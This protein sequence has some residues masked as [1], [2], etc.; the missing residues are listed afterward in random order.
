MAGLKDTDEENEIISSSVAG[1]TKDHL[2]APLG[3]RPRG[4]WRAIFYIIGNESFERLASMGLVMNLSVYLKTK[5]NMY[6]VFLINVVS[7]W[8][9]FCNILPLLGAFIAEKFLGRF[10]TLLLGCSASFIGMTMMALTAG[11]ANLRPASCDTSQSQQDCPQPNAGHLSFLFMALGLIAIGAG[12]IR[13]CCIAF[14]ADQFDATTEEGKKNMLSFYNWWYLSFTATLIIALSV[15]VY[16]QTTISWVIGLAVP[17][18]LLAVSIIVFVIGLPTYVMIKPQGSVYSDLAK[19]VVSSIRK[20]SLRVRYDLDSGPNFYDPPIPESDPPI[21]KLPHT[22]RFPCFDKGCIIANPS[23]LNSEGFPANRWRLCSLQQVEQFKC[24]VSI[25][26]VWISGIACFLVMDQQNVNGILQAIQS[27]PAIGSSFQIPPGW[28]GLTGMFV[29]S[30]WIFF[31]ET[32][33]PFASRRLCGKRCK[34]LTINQRMNLGIV[35]SI[36]AMAIAG[37]VEKRRREM[38]LSRSS[39]ISPMSVAFL[40]PQFGLA[41]LVEAFAAIAILELL[42]SQVPMNLRTVGGAIYFSSLSIASYLTSSIVSIVHS[43]SSRNGRTPWIGGPDLN[44]GRLDYY[45]Y[46][47]AAMSVVNLVYFNLFAKN[48]LSSSRI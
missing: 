6:G 23:E 41:G 24:F 37:I 25:T 45:Y 33:A 27:N 3:S 15:I 30:I 16:I 29:L 18:A 28:L 19:V 42:T 2:S 1:E 7:I 17:A 13:P 26:P 35:A 21:E 39:F 34:R 43:L 46:I 14:G 47:I 36:S 5:Y 31:Y 44:S 11:I 9:G 38:A 22:D 12:C 20:S 10:G 8:S 4:G 32:V 40:L 48:F